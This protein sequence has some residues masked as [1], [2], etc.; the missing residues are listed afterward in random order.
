MYNIKTIN[1]ISPVGL[2]KLKQLGYNV[3]ADIDDPFML[4]S[5]G[6]RLEHSGT[7]R[8]RWIASKWHLVVHRPQPMHLFSSTMLAPQP[9][10]RE[11]SNLTCS[12]VS[13]S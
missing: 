6:T 9:R 13:V 2:D 12:S 11:V 5:L 3:S 4:S 8:L 1:K 10:Q 7:S